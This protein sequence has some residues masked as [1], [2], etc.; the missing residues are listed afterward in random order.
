MCYFVV[1]W[2]IIFFVQKACGKQDIG[3]SSKQQN[4]LLMY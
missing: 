4:L 1:Y 2:A 3:T